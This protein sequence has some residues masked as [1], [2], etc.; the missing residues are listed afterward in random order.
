[1]DSGSTQLIFKI[2][3]D[4]VREKANL[5]FATLRFFKSSVNF[6]KISFENGLHTIKAFFAVFSSAKG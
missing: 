1:M 4:I 5:S 2:S 3:T 6:Q